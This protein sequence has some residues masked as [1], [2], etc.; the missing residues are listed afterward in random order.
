MIGFV[1]KK[2][3]NK[4]FPVTP[5]PT[6]QQTFQQ[7]NSLRKERKEQKNILG[8]FGS[9]ISLKITLLHTFKHKLVIFIRNRDGNPETT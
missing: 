9:G 5:L 3:F 7:D 4:H 2:E 1:G 6:I 8:A